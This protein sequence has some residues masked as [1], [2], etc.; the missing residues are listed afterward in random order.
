MRTHSDATA[1]APAYRT[2]EIDGSSRR[3]FAEAFLFI[4]GG[5]ALLVFGVLAWLRI[6]HAFATWLL[7]LVAAIVVLSAILAR[8]A[9]FQVSTL[10]RISTTGLEAAWSGPLG[11]H[12]VQT[13]PWDELLGVR[14]LDR[15]AGTCVLRTKV[16]LRNPQVTLRQAR[17]ILSYPACRITD[18]PAQVRARIGLPASDEST[19]A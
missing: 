4:M 3:S 12:T 11:G 19:V 18:L 9:S 15:L 5:T 14:S 16:A 17:A 2:I 13:Y 6:P 10:V 1:P 8:F 7:P